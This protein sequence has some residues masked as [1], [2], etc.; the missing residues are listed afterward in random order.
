MRGRPE[1]NGSLWYSTNVEDLIEPSHP[2]RAIKRMVDEALHEMSDAFGAAYSTNGRPGVPSERLLKAL[3]LQSL[4]SIRSEHELC[5]RVK[6]DLLFQWFLDM[7]PDD[8]VFDPTVFTHNRNRLAEDGLITTFFNGVVRQAKDAG[9]TSDEHFT[10]D[11]SLIQSHASLKSLKRIESEALAKERAKADDDDPKTP[12]T[13]GAPRPRS[14]NE[15]VDF[16]G[17]TRGNATHRS[18]TDPH[19]RLARKGNNVGAF[20]CHSVHALTENRHGLVVAI[21]V[22]EANGTAERTCAL[23]LVDR[24][25]QQHHVRVATLGADKG[26]DSGEF[27]VALQQRAI[28]PHVAIRP[29]LIVATD[30]GGRAR[31][32][33]RA[34]QRSTDYCTS[35]R[36][37]KIVDESF[38]WGKTIST[39]R[40]SKHIER[41]KISQQAQLTAAMYNLVRMC[42]L[43]AA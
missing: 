23:A 13:G 35:Q 38:G 37:R 32:A 43:L 14:R 36:R 41:Y 16:R 24:A 4:Y 27:L 20:L 7:R 26:Y 11:G 28:T 8:I 6:T 18:A 22:D 33:A 19:A 39:M 5:R 10:V 29:G 25:R 9:L 40:R 21:S 15:S 2:L 31:R 17:E 1:N 42:R 30:A 12:P 34:R 3:L